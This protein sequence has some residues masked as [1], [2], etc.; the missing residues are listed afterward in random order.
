[1]ILVGPEFEVAPGVWMRH[2]PG[3][4][5]D[6]VTIT[7]E[8]NGQTFCFLSDL[9]PS[10]AHA[11]PSWVSAFD[12]YPLQAIEMKQKWLGMAA[13]GGW[14]CG[15][16]HDPAVDFARIHRDP[17]SQFRAEIVSPASGSGPS[18]AK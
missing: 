16:A 11:Q 7:A 9:V 3:H 15:F 8:S 4:N 14:V 10:H 2:A 6:M 1:M 13:D 17:K 18:P 12:L 5:R